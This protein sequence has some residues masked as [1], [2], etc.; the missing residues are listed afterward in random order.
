[1]VKD[2]TEERRPVITRILT[3]TAHFPVYEHVENCTV[4]VECQAPAW[5]G[6]A[7]LCSRRVTGTRLSQRLEGETDT[8]RTHAPP[9][10]PTH[11]HAHRRPHT[12]THAHAHAHAHARPPI[13]ANGWGGGR[14]QAG[15]VVATA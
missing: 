6:E 14:A 10:P 7:W 3:D 12:R 1:M 8:P 2:G 5:H 11:A 15:V 4:E 9:H 13:S